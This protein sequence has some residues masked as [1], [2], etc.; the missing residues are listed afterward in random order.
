MVTSE[1]TLAGTTN[2]RRRL[3]RLAC[4]QAI[5]GPTPVSTISTSASRPAN[6]LK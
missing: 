5:S 2:C 4:R 1:P 3:A 6:V